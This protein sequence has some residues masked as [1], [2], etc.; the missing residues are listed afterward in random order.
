M[1]IVLSGPLAET[2]SVERATYLND[3]GYAVTAQ[4]GK[5]LVERED[6]RDKQ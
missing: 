1:I 3:Q 6:G 2:V 5:V 4:Y